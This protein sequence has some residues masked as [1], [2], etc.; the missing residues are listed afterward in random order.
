MLKV[1]RFFRTVYHDN[2]RRNDLRR[3]LGRDLLLYARNLLARPR[4][5]RLVAR[6]RRD[7]LP[8]LFIVAPPRSG[9]T[10][11][12]QLLARH[13]EAGF[14]NNFVARHFMVPV[15]GAR[16][17]VRRFGEAALV[18]GGVLDSAYG[19]TEGN[20]APHEFSWFWQYFLEPGAHDHLSDA[21]L[22]RRPAATIR[23]E[24]QGLAGFFGRPLL[25]KSL[26]F[27]DY[28][29]PWLYRILPDARF[30]RIRRES[31][32][33]AQSI[34]EVRRRRYGDEGFWWSI[35]PRDV[36]AWRDRDPLEQVAHQVR[37]VDVALDR[38]LASL[39][40]GARHEITYEELT[41]DPAEVL[42]G[43][44]DFLGVAM[45]DRDILAGLRLENRNVKRLP[46]KRFVA[47]ERALDTIT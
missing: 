23:D 4:E 30:L 25:L 26:N 29:V 18:P 40:T 33:T 6:H 7:D 28:H 2:R 36:D 42:A 45:R 17:F 20:A 1:R 38:D 3:P 46:E 14:P 32:H 47:L 37:D 22:A 21:E 5:R 9:T 44:A 10:L 27:V 39:P 24:L 13:L 15:L 8:I 19:R 41:A 34:L 43:I 35:R 31:V 16:R 11:L 12:Y